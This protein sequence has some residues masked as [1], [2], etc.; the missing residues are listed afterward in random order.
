MNGKGE[1]MAS[2][3]CE[4]SCCG[5]NVL[6]HSVEILPQNNNWFWCILKHHANGTKT[7]AGHGYAETISQ[8]GEQAENYYNTYI[9]AEAE[10]GDKNAISR[11]KNR[12]RLAEAH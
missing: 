12:Q 3:N 5:C 2:G 7:N 9:A 6:S 11:N 4:N 1:K 10:Q 8:A